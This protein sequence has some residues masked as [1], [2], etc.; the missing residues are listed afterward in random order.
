VFDGAVRKALR[1]AI[2]KTP[3]S[4]LADVQLERGEK[5]TVVR[6]V[7]RGPRQPSAQ[8]VATL[9]SALPPDPERSKLELRVRFIQTVTVT[10]QGILFEDTDPMRPD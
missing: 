2:S 1:I 5:V 3:G 7:M 6:A 8:E 9:A 10:P 4:H